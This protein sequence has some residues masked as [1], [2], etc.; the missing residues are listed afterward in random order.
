MNRKS[1]KLKSE[2]CIVLNADAKSLWQVLTEPWFTKEY[3]F[4][5]EVKS[6]W[7][8]GSSIT[9]QGNFE[10][11]EAYQ[12]GEILDIVPLERMKY[13][14]FDPNFGLED[15]PENYIH[16]SYILKELANSTEQI[17]HGPCAGSGRRRIPADGFC[18]LKPGLFCPL[19]PDDAR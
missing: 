4:N 6:D 3:M 14:T 7:K 11:Y 5:C 9:W 2:K 18:H 12:K 16:V 19:A 1:L 10:G 15:K 8:T 13:S 17:F